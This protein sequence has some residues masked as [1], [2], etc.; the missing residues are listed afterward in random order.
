VP[1]SRKWPCQDCQAAAGYLDMH[2]LFPD[3]KHCTSLSAGSSKPLP[4]AGGPAKTT[5]LLPVILTCIP[6]TLAAVTSWMVAHSSQKRK[7]LYIHTAIPAVVGGKLRFCSCQQPCGS[8]AAASCCAIVSMRLF[9]HWIARLRA[10]Q[11]W[12]HALW[13]LTSVA[14]YMLM[15]LQACSLCCSLSCPA[16]R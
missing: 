13:L 14:C 9:S 5:K 8:C 12:I 2:T 1:A 16:C 10:C 6:Y 11:S 7:E 4:P 15:A 3:F